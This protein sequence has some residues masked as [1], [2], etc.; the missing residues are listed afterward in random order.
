[1][2][3]LEPKRMWREW[4]IWCEQM[5]AGVLQGWV[6]A[7]NRDTFLCRTE[8]GFLQ[9][10][11]GSAFPHGVF[12]WARITLHNWN[13]SRAVNNCLQWRS[14]SD[15]WYGSHAALIS[16]L[17]AESVIN[18]ETEYTTNSLKHRGSVVSLSRL[19]INHWIWSILTQSVETQGSEMCYLFVALFIVWILFVAL[20]V[21]IKCSRV[22]CVQAFSPFAVYCT[23]LL[24]AANIQR[25]DV[26]RFMCLLPFD[27]TTKHDLLFNLKLC[28]ISYIWNLCKY[29]PS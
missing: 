1:M 8:V 12:D 16:I 17:W 19:N 10:E 28:Y 2:H 11:L 6:S 15:K 26:K 22:Y 13:P 25:T 9:T 18:E 7:H 27:T 5:V 24:F 29:S 21:G 20:F 14:R 4:N 23:K 3:Y